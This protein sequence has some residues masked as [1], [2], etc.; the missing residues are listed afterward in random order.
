[1][2]TNVAI[3]FEGQQAGLLTL[4]NNKPDNLLFVNQCTQDFVM[5]GTSCAEAPTLV[6]SNVS[7]T[8]LTGVGSNFSAHE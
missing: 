2:V 7:E 3:I 6:T 1:M 5:P 4:D 8:S